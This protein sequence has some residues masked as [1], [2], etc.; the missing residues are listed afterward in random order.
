MRKITGR[1]EAAGLLELEEPAQRYR[2]EMADIPDPVLEDTASDATEE[3][4]LRVP[5]RVPVRRRGSSRLGWNSRKA[6]VLVAVSVLAGLGL[7]GAALWQARNYLLHGREFVL[8][9][10]QAVQVTGNRVVRASDVQRIFA[11]DYGHSVFRVPLAKR[12]SQLEQIPWVKLARVMRLWPDRLKVAIVERAPVAF[13]RD[14]NTIRLAD[15]DGVLLDLPEAAAQRYSFPVIRGISSADPISTRAARMQIYQRFVQA[16]DA[17]GGHASA[18]L[19]EVDLSDP[20]DVR[21]VFSDGPRDPVVHFGDSDFLAR[22]QV[23]RAHLTEWLKQYPNLAS[24]DVR[25]GRQV[26]LDVGAPTEAAAGTATQPAG[27]TAG[28]G[29]ASAAAN[30]TARPSSRQNRATHSAGKH[31]AGRASS[32]HGSRP[33]SGPGSRH[34]SGSRKK[35]P[36]QHSGSHATQGAVHSTAVGA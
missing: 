27:D 14:G 5:K 1:A 15:G 8:E 17:D 4:F 24:V 10:S 28:D 33:D 35:H 19:S 36:A 6:R 21:A 20:Q 26:V 31:S 18:S 32:G 13:A 29:A 23:Y 12:Q 2:P 11:S 3:S 22:Y 30:K 9:S 25:Y 7:M 34:G 16:L